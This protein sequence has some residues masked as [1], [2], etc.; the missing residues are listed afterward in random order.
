MH[1]FEYLI[2][3]RYAFLLKFSSVGIICF[4]LCLCVHK[5]REIIHLG[6]YKRNQLTFN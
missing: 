5:Y 1:L 2:T 6:V 4:V 3:Y